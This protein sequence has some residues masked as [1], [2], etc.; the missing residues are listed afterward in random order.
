VR[1]HHVS[2]EQVVT[3]VSP[4]VSPGGDVIAVPRSN[5]VVIS[6]I[7]DNASR[8]R[9]LVGRFDSDTFENMTG[10]VYKI[11]HGVVEDVAQELQTIL[12]TYHVAERRATARRTRARVRPS[13]RRS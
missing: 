7:A 8:L 5:I 13:R 4:F 2:A 9:E 1:V 12:E 10:K 6:D 3:L 11:E